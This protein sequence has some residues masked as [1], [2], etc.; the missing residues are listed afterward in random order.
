MI[1]EIAIGIFGVML[2]VAA[3]PSAEA[4]SEEALSPMES[5][6]NSNS[7]SKPIGPRQSTFS[8]FAD[9]A[10]P[11]SQYI[12]CAGAIVVAEREIDTVHFGC[13]EKLYSG[14]TLENKGPRWKL[15]DEGDM[16]DIILYG[17]AINETTKKPSCDVRGPPQSGDELQMV[18]D[19][20]NPSIMKPP[21]GFRA[22]A[23][24]DEQ[25]ER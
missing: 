18:I 17:C 15:T 13:K 11:T 21:Q 23:P 22:S 25:G 4:Q 24:G 14:A 9:G 20:E 6:S 3:L 1:S 19:L 16:A 8:I 7:N 2:L 12:I 5:E 10:T